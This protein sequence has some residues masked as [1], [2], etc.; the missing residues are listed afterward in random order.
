MKNPLFA[1]IVAM[2]TAVLASKL[3]PE[4]YTVVTTNTLLLEGV[5]NGVKTGTTPEAGG[6][7]VT[8]YNVGPNQVLTVVLGSD[9]EENAEGIQ[10]STA[11]YED[12]RLLMATVDEDFV[13]V[14]PSNPSAPGPLI[15]LRQELQVWGV[16]VASAAFIPIPAGRDS[17]VSYRLVLDAGEADAISGEVRFYLDDTVLSELDAVATG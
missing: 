14:D 12:T 7:L 6:C 3:R 9:V 17:D 15:E 8:S 16:N 11:R 10:D 1:E 13:W 2:P 4:G 5:A